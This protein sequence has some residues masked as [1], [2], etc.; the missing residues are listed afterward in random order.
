M[1]DLGK[2]LLNEFQRDMPLTARPY[3]AMAERL[4]VGEDQVIET[5]SQLGEDGVLSRVGAVFRPGAVGHSTLAAMS[6]P[7]ERLESVADL[8]SGFEAVNHNYQREHKFN[9]W[10]VIAARDEREIGRVIGK[11]ERL[12]GIGVLNLPMLEDY[13]LDLGFDLEW[14]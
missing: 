7:G 11:I 8:V 9:L 10:F 1:N 6:V 3:L 14:N 13:H 5:L 12:T 2:N 4:G